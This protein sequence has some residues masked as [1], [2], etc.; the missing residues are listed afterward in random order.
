MIPLRIEPISATGGQTSRDM[1][2]WF[3]PPRKMQ[4]PHKRGLLQRVSDGT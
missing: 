3:K 2:D 4:A 1:R